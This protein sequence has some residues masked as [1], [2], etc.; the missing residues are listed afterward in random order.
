MLDRRAEPGGDSEEDSEFSVSVYPSG[1]EAG[2]G[3]SVTV[4]AQVIRRRRGGQSIAGGIARPRRGEALDALICS[5]RAA[6]Q[7]GA[8]GGMACSR[9]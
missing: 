8:G 7:Q 9:R 3:L 2:T 5:I 1:G 6:E 4:A